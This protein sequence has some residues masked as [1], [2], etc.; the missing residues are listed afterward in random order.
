[1]FRAARV[2]SSRSAYL[3]ASV[4]ACAATWDGAFAKTA[5]GCRHPTLP[6]FHPRTCTRTGSLVMFL[7]RE[8][9]R[10]PRPRWS[11]SQEQPSSPPPPLAWRRRRRPPA[12][13]TWATR[14]S[15]VHARA[16]VAA[17]VLLSCHGHRRHRVGSRP[18]L[19]RRLLRTVVRKPTERRWRSAR[20]AEEILRLC[21]R[22]RER[23][24]PGLC[25]V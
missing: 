10:A 24:P 16:T 4:W 9:W 3:H 11:T 2:I 21:A 15:L 23:L 18:E 13:S 17:A 7:L 1:M 5:P 6:G 12:A 8:P 19:R 25:P 20:P 22:G 14:R